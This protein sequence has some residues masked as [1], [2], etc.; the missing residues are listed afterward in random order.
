M[1]RTLPAILKAPEMGESVVW[2]AGEAA[3][4]Y[5]LVALCMA[6]ALL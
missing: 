4:H 3:V 2:D 6:K 5:L 1:K